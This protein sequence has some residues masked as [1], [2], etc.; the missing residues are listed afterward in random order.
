MVT[1]EE[2]NGQ[3]QQ[4]GESHLD[5]KDAPDGISNPWS[6][7]AIVDTCCSFPPDEHGESRTEHRTEKLAHH[8][9]DKIVL[10][11][12]ALQPER[13]RDSGVE[14][15]TAQ[16]AKRRDGYERPAC[17]QQQPRYQLTCAA[18]EKHDSHDRTRTK[19]EGHCA[20]HDEDEKRGS[21]QF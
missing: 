10:M 16:L 13:Q 11:H 12:L 20:Y 4:A 14:M 3:N 2:K 5:E 7:D 19:T 15:G 1:D 9:A 21:Q 18:I 6:R 17:C 8:I